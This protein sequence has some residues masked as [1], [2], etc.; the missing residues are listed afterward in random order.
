M[1]HTS[2]RWTDI[3]APDQRM[4]KAHEHCTLHY[5]LHRWYQFD[6]KGQPHTKLNCNGAIEKEARFREVLLS[7]Q[8]ALLLLLLL[9][10]PSGLSYLQNLAEVEADWAISPAI[11]SARANMIPMTRT[12]AGKRSMG[13]VDW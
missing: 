12:A 9:L 6:W 8:T 3:M 2:L 1:T 4:K 5:I 10:A 11:G 13:L 7:M